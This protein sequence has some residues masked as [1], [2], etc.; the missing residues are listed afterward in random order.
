MGSDDIS[1]RR[2]DGLCEEFCIVPATQIRKRHFHANVGRDNYFFIDR[3]LCDEHAEKFDN[4]P[5]PGEK[6]WREWKAN[7]D[8]EGGEPREPYLGTKAKPQGRKKDDPYT[9]F[10]EP[11]QQP[12][13]KTSTQDKRPKAPD[14]P[15]CTNTTM[16]GDVCRKPIARKFLDRKEAMYLLCL[17]CAEDLQIE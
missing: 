4:D 5:P 12:R 10:G 16:I 1:G 8:R 11:K 9:N 17:E 15:T 14:H 2:C 6:D 13:R 3:Y 7:P